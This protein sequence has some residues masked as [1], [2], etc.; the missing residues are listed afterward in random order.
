[1]KS[2][3]HAMV[4][5][6]GIFL[7]LCLAVSCATVPELKV[8]YLLPITSDEL[9]GKSV[10]LAFRDDREK[11]DIMS[12]GAK[13]RFGP[14]AGN[15]SL[16]LNK[17]TV[18]KGTSLGLFD[19]RSLFMEVFN[20]RLESLGI[21]VVPEKKMTQLDLAIILKE[22]SLDLINKKWVARMAYEARLESSG[23]L[24]K[25]Q[26][27]SGEAE[28]LRIMGN[29]QAE[30]VMSEIFTDIINRLDIGSLFRYESTE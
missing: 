6:T 21:S 13:Q 3:D 27:I 23:K 7:I 25:N 30:T 16:F 4:G 10:F 26:I 2:R 11:K 8:H 12:E 1:M 28:R 15:V 22:F 20:R 5:I 18:G 19:V 14:F 24:L 17:G 29:S 9:K